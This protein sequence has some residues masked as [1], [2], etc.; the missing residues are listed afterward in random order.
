MAAAVAWVGG[1]C[2][3]ARVDSSGRTMTSDLADPPRR[4]AV[5]LPPYTS[6]V[7]RSMAVALVGGS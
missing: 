3:A 2:V 1:G 7:E 5:L 6:S 4:R